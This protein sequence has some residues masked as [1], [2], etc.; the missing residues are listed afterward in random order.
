MSFD[1]LRVGDL[2]TRWAYH[3]RGAGAAHLPVYIDAGEAP[4]HAYIDAR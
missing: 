3:L 1:R 2:A 4:R